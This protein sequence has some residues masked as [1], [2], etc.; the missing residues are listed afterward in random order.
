MVSWIDD[1]VAISRAPSQRDLDFIVH[2]FGAITALV[3]FY[4]LEYDLDKIRGLGLEVLHHPIPELS[5]P[6]LIELH[7]IVS[8]IAN[9]VEQGRK[10]LVHCLAGYGRSGTIAAGYLAYRYGLSGDEAIL[11]VRDRRP[12]AIETFSQEAVIRAYAL[13]TKVLRPEAVKAVFS[14]GERFDWGRGHRHASAVTQISL[15]LWEQ[16][17]DELNLGL[18]EAG[19]LAVASLLHDIGA[20]LDSDGHHEKTYELMLSSKELRVLGDEELDMAAL[21]ALHHRARTNP[22]DDSRVKKYGNVI[23]KTSALI[24]ISDAL[25]YNS[26]HVIDDVEVHIEDEVIRISVFSNNIC[27][28]EIA[29]AQERS[30]LLETLT[31]KKVFFD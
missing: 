1:W 16:L 23:A 10:V 22:L 29:R 18:K 30:T 25:D 19:A 11:R 31:G 2:T 24:R 4:D 20:T 14:V 13:L 8:F 17:K 6:S 3:D 21:I 9:C 15:R 27:D 12:G 7:K 28:A 5:A 26:R